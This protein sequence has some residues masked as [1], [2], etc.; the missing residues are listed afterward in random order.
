[1]SLYLTLHWSITN[2]L[3]TRADRKYTEMLQVSANMKHKPI[4]QQHREKFF[5]LI[6]VI[7]VHFEIKIRE[8]FNRS[9]Y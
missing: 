7:F 1:M 4:A 3:Y 2:V 5:A 6:C 8:L 9:K